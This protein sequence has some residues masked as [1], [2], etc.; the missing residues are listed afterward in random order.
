MDKYHFLADGPIIDHV[1]SHFVLL[2]L[3]VRNNHGD[4]SLVTPE[5]ELRIVPESIENRL[6][7]E[8]EVLFHNLGT[9]AARHVLVMIIICKECIRAVLEVLHGKLPPLFDDCSWNLLLGWHLSPH[10][11]HQVFCK[12]LHGVCILWGRDFISHEVALHFRD[13]H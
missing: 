12:L 5:S 10:F 9:H 6:K 8:H 11:D 4:Q 2:V 3:K 7:L 13:T 1:C